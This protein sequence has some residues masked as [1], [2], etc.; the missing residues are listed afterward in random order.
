MK[1][2]LLPIIGV[3]ASVPQQFFDT[4][5]RSEPL[6]PEKALVM[7]IL[8]DAIHNFHKYRE[9]R[10]RPGQELYHEAEEWLLGG[11]DNWI[12]AFDSVCELLGLDPG[13]IRRGLLQSKESGR[14][15]SRHRHKVRR[16]AA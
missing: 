11:G 8:Q 16:R 10:D 14:D 5:R 7:A 15:K 2:S 1:E 13:Y 9:A 4:F 12:F 3:D 6:E